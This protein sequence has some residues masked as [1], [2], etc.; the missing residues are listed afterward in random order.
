MNQ[1]LEAYIFE[2]IPICNA[3]VPVRYLSIVTAGTNIIVSGGWDKKLNFGDARSP[4]PVANIDLP[5]KCYDIDVKNGV[6]AVAT[7]VLVYD[8]N[9]TA[10]KHM[11]KDSPIY[12]ESNRELLHGYD[13]FCRGEH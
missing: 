10:R 12:E 5:D 13:G 11:W 4:N 8:V 2:R 6:M 3:T 1:S 7:G 9:G